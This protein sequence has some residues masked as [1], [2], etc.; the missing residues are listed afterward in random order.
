MPSL[1]GSGWFRIPALRFE[2]PGILRRWNF[3]TKNGAASSSPRQHFC[4]DIHKTYTRCAREGEDACYTRRQ[5]VLTPTR[6]Y[7][8]EI[9][10]TLLPLYGIKNSGE[11]HQLV[12]VL[13]EYDWLKLTERMQAFDARHDAEK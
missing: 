10:D 2:V 5:N 3:P 6:D 9:L 4:G 11:V 12:K 7:A 1:D 8:N 13:Q